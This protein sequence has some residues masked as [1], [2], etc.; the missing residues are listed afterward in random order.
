MVIF[1]GHAMADPVL[2]I[3]NGRR[4]QVL[5]SLFLIRSSFLS[6]PAGHS[7]CIVASAHAAFFCRNNRFGA[8]LLSR[9]FPVFSKSFRYDKARIQKRDIAIFIGIDH[10]EAILIPVDMP[11]AVSDYDAIV[12]ILGVV[13]R[14]NPL[15]AVGMK[16]LS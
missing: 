16:I 15:P 8:V 12:C 3:G 10:I 14:V 13:K 1:T 5:W 4:C 2:A 11:K 7:L 6:A 9:G